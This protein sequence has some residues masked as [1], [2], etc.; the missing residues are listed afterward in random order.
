MGDF[1]IERFLQLSGPVQIND[2]DWQAAGQAGVTD[3]EHR[4]LRYMA[5]TETH[6]ILYLRDLLAGHTCNDAEVTAFLSVWVYEE[7][8]HGR[9]LDMLLE[10]SGRPVPKDTYTKVSKS[11]S[12][13]EP[14]EAFFSH[15]GAYATPKFAALHMAWGAINELTAAAAYKSLE[16]RTKNKPLA[17]LLNRIMKQERKHFSFYYHQAEKRLQGDVWAQRLCS[18]ALRHFWTP[19]GAGV[20]HQDNLVFVANNLFD[21][22]AG[23]KALDECDETIRK[24][25]GLEWFN[26]VSTRVN[27]L[28]ANPQPP[29][30]LHA[31][32]PAESQVS[33][34]A[35]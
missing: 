23:G 30:S 22:A 7:L 32:R 3:A 13:R 31:A 35:D 5:D 33:S 15:L 16:R 12:W 17:V 25:P 11:V 10:A 2:L 24:L 18:F 21:D 29:A 27:K 4:I 19:V 6:T 8:W 20:G 9:A 1:D 28:I 14:I 34:V 26:L